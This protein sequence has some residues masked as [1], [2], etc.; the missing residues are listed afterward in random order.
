MFT[1]Q[2]AQNPTPFPGV[3]TYTVWKFQ[4]VKW[5]NV[6]VFLDINGNLQYSDVHPSMVFHNKDQAVRAINKWER[7]NLPC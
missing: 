6:T 1:W 3:F 2:I 5:G 4:M 7:E